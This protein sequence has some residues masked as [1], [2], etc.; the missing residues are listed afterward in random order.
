M[1]QTVGYI[2]F[3]TLTILF[4]L[5]WGF[6]VRKLGGFINYV[7]HPW[8]SVAIFAAAILVGLG[9]YYVAM[10]VQDPPTEEMIRN[11]ESGAS[12]EDT[13]SYEE[14]VGVVRDDD[15]G[16][17][18][19]ASERT[20][21]KW[22][23]MHPQNLRIARDNAVIRA[24]Q[25]STAAGLIVAAVGYAILGMRLARKNAEQEALAAEAA[26]A[27]PPPPAPPAAPA[28]T[29][30]DLRFEEDAPPR[31]P[32]P[33]AVPDVAADEPPLES[34]DAPISIDDLDKDYKQYLKDKEGKR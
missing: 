34:G 11:A 31:A 10:A 2:L 8:Q 28:F 16:E 20:G 24:R 7:N 30:A 29:A 3:G 25:A 12:P 9:V 6:Y 22:V 17:T 19:D 26:A 15:A 27:A 4:V 13:K 14:S 18:P 33:P 32:G 21:N 23:G 5:A 1:S